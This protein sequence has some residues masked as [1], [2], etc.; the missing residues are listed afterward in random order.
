MI[1]DLRAA[2]SQFEMPSSLIPLSLWAYQQRPLAYNTAT[3]FRQGDPDLTRDFKG[4]ILLRS[5]SLESIE[6]MVFAF[7]FVL[8][9]DR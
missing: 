6:I 9:H 2:D 1:C 3:S 8:L 5:F 4:A 7:I